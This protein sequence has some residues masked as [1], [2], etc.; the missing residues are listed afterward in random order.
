M[1]LGGQCEVAASEKRARIRRQWII[2][3][4]ILLV[5][6]ALA[7]GYVKP[8]RV[9]GYSD[10]P[11]YL[12]NDL[13]L[14]NKLAY[15]LRLPYTDVVLV[16][17]SQPLP[18][19]VVMFISP[20]YGQRVFKRVVG[21]PGDRV[22]IK[23]NHLKINSVFLDYHR[24]KAQFEERVL[25]ENRIGPVVEIERGI[26]EPHTITHTPQELVSKA[27]GSVQVPPNH[28]YVIGDNRSASLDSRQYGPIH[29]NTILGK[30]SRPFR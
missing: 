16:A 15:D 24:V 23:D 14:V 6:I 21:V 2:G 10:S 22:E 4:F 26:G 8:N 30:V 29:R 5:L 1:P 17:H 25:S 9:V 28:F 11:T 18:G 13:I 19:D 20:D 27:P 12:V 7:R 3:L